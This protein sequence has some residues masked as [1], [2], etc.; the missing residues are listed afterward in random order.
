MA[1][2]LHMHCHGK[3]SFMHHIDSFYDLAYEA[4][5]FV[6]GPAINQEQLILL[7]DMPHF[8]PLGNLIMDSL[9]HII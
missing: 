9:E 8:A 2:A 7:E 6:F 4:S 1:H 5:F 3:E